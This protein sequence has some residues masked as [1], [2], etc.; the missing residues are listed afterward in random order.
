MGLQVAAG[1]Q[2]NNVVQRE[3]AKEGPRVGV[4][5]GIIDLGMQE[6]E[7]QG[8][9]QR[10]CREFLPIITLVSDLYTDDEG[11]KHCMVTSPWPIKIKLGEKSNYTKFTKAADP[12]G[13]VLEDGVGDLSKLIGLPVF[14][15]MVHTQGSGDAKDITYANCK[16]IQELP[17]DFHPKDVEY[18]EVVF[19]ASNPD[20]EVFDKL[21]ER[22]QNL[23]TGSP[24]WIGFGDQEPTR[25][26]TTADLVNENI[27][28]DIPF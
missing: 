26:V 22:T 28:D 15:N 25:G 4:I 1:T 19:D 14:A 3:I 2:T 11:V 17:E 20:K 6:Q 10:D 24:S 7:Y 21:W 12:R 8:E 13:E 16:G 5:S 9:K 23:I 18:N 27:D